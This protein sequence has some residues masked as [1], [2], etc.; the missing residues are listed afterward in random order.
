VFVESPRL[1]R[2]LESRLQLQK[3]SIIAP[4]TLS[5]SDLIG[6]LGVPTWCVT[7][8]FVMLAA[9]IALMKGSLPSNVTA[10]PGVRSTFKGG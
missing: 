9:S 10:V 4:V 8:Q 7:Q 2:L 6:N 5:A 1:S 3:Y